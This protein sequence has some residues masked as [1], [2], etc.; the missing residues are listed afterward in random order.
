LLLGLLVL[1]TAA[2][3]LR[4]LRLVGGKLSPLRRVLTP[5]NEVALTF[6]ISWGTTVPPKVADILK[7]YGV[8]STIFVS[9]PWARQNPDLVRRLASDGHE[10]ASHGYAHQNMSAWDA[11]QI[12]QAITR[13]HQVLKELTGQ[14]A[15]YI[16]PPNGDYDDLVISTAA[17]LGYTVVIWSQDSRDWMNPGPQKIVD[18]LLSRT[19]PGDIVLM[20]ASNTCNQT[21]TA[22][23]LVI[24]GLRAKGLVLVTL[25]EL[26][27]GASVPK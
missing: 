26:L 4:Q 19:G 5:R 14:E 21:D 13:T 9:G 16:R 24:E 22:L 23:P 7:R 15:R 1:A 12:S 11:D 2:A 3:G 10:L 8:R 27:A 20:H 18:R 17:E 6:D 25:T